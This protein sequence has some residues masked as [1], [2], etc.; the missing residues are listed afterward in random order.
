MASLKRSAL[1]E[2]P[3]VRPMVVS[4]ALVFVLGFLVLPL[5]AVF[6]EALRKGVTAYVD[7]IGDPDALSAIKL[8]F[9][10]AGIA[11]PLNVIFGVAASWAIAKFDFRGKSL[12]ITLI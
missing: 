10:A 5:V 11:V 4:L 8:T 2:S 1:T 12:L 9:I 3:A 7:A 6:T